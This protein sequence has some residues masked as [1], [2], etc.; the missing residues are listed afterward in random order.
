MATKDILYPAGRLIGG[1]VTKGNSTDSKG[2]PKV[3]KTGANK[4]Q[5]YTEWSFGVAF[6][7]G[8]ETSW[9][10]TPWGALIYAAGIE[11]YPNGEVQMPVFSWKVIDGDSAIPN[12]KLKKPCDQTGYPGHWVV[13]FSSGAAPKLYDIIGMPA[14]GQPKPLGEK[15]ILPGDYVQVFGTAKDNKPSET[16]GVYLNHNIVALVGHGE[17]ISS[18]PDVNEVGFGGAVLP[19]GAS[20]V[21]IGGMVAPALLPGQ[22]APLPVAAAL[23]VAPAP[24]TIAVQPNPAILAAAITPPPPAAALA[25]PPPALD[26]NGPPPGLTMTGAYTYKQLKDANYSDDQ[27]VAQQFAQ[28]A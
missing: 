19:A 26:P 1:S 20:T 13:W 3:V 14:G 23:P 17:R 12:K 5:P 15:Q 25:P 9:A 4:G 10:Q 28:R 21:P 6:Q 7:K 18:G 24:A 22:V 16:P 2:Q 8:P 11:G 27:M